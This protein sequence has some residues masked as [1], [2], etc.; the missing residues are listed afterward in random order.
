MLHFHATQKL[1]NTSR[2]KPVL[3]VSEPSPGQRLHNWYVV[4]CGSGFTGKMLLLYIHEPS[5]LTVVV[6]GKTIAST[7]DNFRIQLKELLHRHGFP[8]T[9]IETEMQYAADYIVGKTSS[10]S[11]LAHINQMVLQVTTY[12]LRY[13]GYDEVD[14]RVHEDIFMDWLYKRKEEKDYQTPLTYWMKELGDKKLTDL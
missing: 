14:I 13:A 5:L 1:L 8:K 10:K 9:F 4:L 7:I 3:Y 2:I 6:K 11:M 12:N